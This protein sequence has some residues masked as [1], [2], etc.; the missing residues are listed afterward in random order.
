MSNAKTNSKK[1][2]DGDAFL[3]I[4]SK[5]NPSDRLF[6]SIFVLILAI[7]TAFLTRFPIL[8]CYAEENVEL[9]IRICDLMKFNAIGIFLPLAPLIIAIVYISGQSDLKKFAEY[10]LITTTLIGCSMISLVDGMHFI[11][12]ITGKAVSINLQGCVFPLMIGLLLFVVQAENI[13]DGIM[14]KEREA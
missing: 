14:C 8:T 1:R 12:E 5:I 13:L 6:P 10:I 2:F 3:E 4:L 9:A 11:Y 7:T